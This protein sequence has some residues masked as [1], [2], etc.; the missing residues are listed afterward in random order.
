MHT[1][2]HFPCAPFLCEQVDSSLSRGRPEPGPTLPAD[3]TPSTKQNVPPPTHPAASTL[4]TLSPGDL[5]SSAAEA[6]ASRGQEW[7]PWTSATEN[8]GHG[9]RT[10]VQTQGPW[11]ETGPLPCFIC[12]APCFYLAAAPSSLPLVKE[13]L[14]SYSPKITFGPLKATARLMWPPVKM[15]LTPWSR[16]TGTGGLFLMVRTTRQFCC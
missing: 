12:P 14:H 7:P 2:D 1:P 4:S 3:P 16:R 5:L 13:Q 15:S 9:S 11:A 8:K 10:Q 6:L